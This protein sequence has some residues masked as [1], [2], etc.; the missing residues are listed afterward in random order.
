MGRFSGTVSVLAVAV[1]VGSLAACGSGAQG[2]GAPR[3]D[4]P[5]APVRVVVSVSQWGDIVQRLAGDCGDV[6]TIVTG[7]SGDPH[8]Y[9][10]SPSDTAELGDAKLVMMNGLGYDPWVGK[11][12][13][14]LDHRPTVIDAGKVAG[15][16]DGDNPHIW[17]GPSFVYEVAKAV[18]VRLAELAPKAVA[19]L[20]ARHRAWRASMAPYDAEIARIT[21]AARGKTYGA[22]EGVFD[23]M[24]HAVGLVN[25]T[26]P[27][28]RR[29]TANGS[30]PAPGDVHDF[31]QALADGRMAVL[32][33]NT[34]TEGAIP[35]QARREA[36]TARV[37]VVDV[38]ETVPTGARSFVSWQVGQLRRL[39]AALG[40]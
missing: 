39:A 37:P 36:E 27:G 22:T 38:T 5:V 29:A 14:T 34:Q 2:G 17:Y 33:F 28:Y 23:D 31:Q 26:P 1:A 21:P 15:L 24:A 7:S 11:A 12:L 19:Y 30:D 35:D 3:G 32:V 40:A 25:E 10:P 18:T 6:S 13:D 16:H 20:D 8:D 9:E 4:C